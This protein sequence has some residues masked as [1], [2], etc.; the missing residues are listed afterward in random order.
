MI[1]QCL[2]KVEQTFRDFMNHEL[3][4]SN[5]F[6]ITDEEVWNG[7]KERSNNRS[8]HD[9][10]FINRMNRYCTLVSFEG[11]ITKPTMHTKSSDYAVFKYTYNECSSFEI[12]YYTLS[13]QH[14]FCDE[15][16][17]KNSFSGNGNPIYTTF[18]IIDEGK[19]L[20]RTIQPE[21]IF[22]NPS[23]IGASIF[24]EYSINGING[25]NSLKYLP[26]FVLMDNTDS[27]FL[28]EV[29][30]SLLKTKVFLLSL[31]EKFPTHLM[32]QL[33]NN[34]SSHDVSAIESEF[35]SLYEREISRFINESL[36]SSKQDLENR[37]IP[38]ALP[39]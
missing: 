28:K 37:G 9:C 35:R 11:H 39:F 18:D 24:M 7:L 14:T 17:I 34:L 1:N 31:V 8:H 23:N 33:P 30:N 27:F 19:R 20:N 36:S 22:D 13:S 25:F 32:P 26:S 10:D 15:G 6:S 5:P 3:I 2:K 29:R 12:L 16:M 4:S 21:S 38:L